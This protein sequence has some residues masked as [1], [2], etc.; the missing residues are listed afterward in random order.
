VVGWYRAESDIVA[1]DPARAAMDG[2]GG[3]DGYYTMLLHELLH[4]TG[5]PSRLDR[6]TTGD[7]SIK[8]NALE[9]GT[10]RFAERIVLAELGFP[11]EALEWYLPSN[12][13]GLPVCALPVDRRSGRRAA[14]WVLR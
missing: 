1:V 13:P 11:E 14:A 7:Y 5:H 4:A 2:M 8:G 12:H 3:E 6:A 10:V 9:E